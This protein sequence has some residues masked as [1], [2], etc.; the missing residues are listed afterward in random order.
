MTN[1]F[2]DFYQY[3]AKRV[4]K[5]SLDSILSFYCYADYT[6]PPTSGIKLS[7]NLMA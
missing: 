7:P 3:V 4:A 5:V 2:L 1:R 6:Q